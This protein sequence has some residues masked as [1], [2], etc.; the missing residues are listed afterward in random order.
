MIYILILLKF[1]IKVFIL[2]NFLFLQW[3]R[4]CDTVVRRGEEHDCY[5]LD[6][7]DKNDSYTERLISEVY[8]RESLWNSTLPYKQRGPTDM[9]L[10][11]SEVDSCLSKSILQYSTQFSLQK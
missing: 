9:K 1:V 3:C 6:E 4:D 11:W 2:S 8:M 7:S 10:L 5:I